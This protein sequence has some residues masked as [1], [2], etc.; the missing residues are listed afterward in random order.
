MLS[1]W[2]GCGRRAPLPAGGEGAAAELVAFMDYFRAVHPEP[3]RFVSEEVLAEIVAREARALA[4]IEAPTELEIG[5]AFHAVLAPVADAHVK[6]GL[7]MYQDAEGLSLLPILPV[8]VDGDVW[9]DAAVGPA[10][11]SGRLLAID[12][13]PIEALVSALSGL[14]LADGTGE[15]PRL[16]ALWWDFPRYYHLSHPMQARY[17]LTVEQQGEVRDL[18]VDGIGGDQMS[19]LRSG[20]RSL[21]WGEPDAAVAVH[22]LPG[23]R[24]R[25]RL[26]A[27]GMADMDA[28]RQQVDAAFEEIDAAAPPGLVLD[29]RGNEGGFRP[30]A[31]AV[32]D[33]LLSEPYPQWARFGVRTTKLPDVSP[34][35]LTALLG[36]LGGLA[37]RFPG[38]GRAAEGDPLL[39]WMKPSEAPYPGELFVFVD[40][41]TGSAANTF[42]LALKRYRPDVV[43]LGEELGGACDQHTG[44]FPVVYQA[45]QA[46]VAILHSLVRIEHVAVSGCQRGRG[47]LPDIAVTDS[48]ETFLAGMDPYVAALPE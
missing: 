23:G 1:L 9:I 43:I 31:F 32:L 20:R 8:S 6:V 33:H 22:P 26:P 41:R 39:S 48:A 44:E 12:G 46:P 10:E 29:V 13:Q 34:A 3:H 35:T 15:A 30:N 36:D 16:R 28:Y 47:L 4:A 14:V 18:V 45:A 21:R 27:F 19:A 5:R 40:G 11:A 37:E 42:V 7:Q 38:R 25:L 2:L 17:T 24:L